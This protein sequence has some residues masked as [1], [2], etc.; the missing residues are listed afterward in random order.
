MGKDYSH[1]ETAARELREA[2]QK[3]RILQ[4][5]TRFVS[6]LLYV[7]HVLDAIVGLLVEEFKL[8]ACS[9]RLLDKD[10]NLRIRSHAGLSRAFIQQSTRKPTVDSYSGECFLTGKI[11]II[12]DSGEIDK[13]ISTT[14]TVCENIRSFAVAPIIVEGEAIG[15]LVTSS[16][17]KGY[18]HERYN[19]VITIIANQI[20]IA[21]R[22]SQ[23]YEEINELN[24]DLEKKVK[25]RTEEL[26]RKTRKLIEVERLAA[27]GKM[28]QR[29]AHDC[30][31]SLTVVGGLARRLDDK[32]SEEDP[33]KEYTRIIVDE[34]KNLEKKVSSIINIDKA[35]L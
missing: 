9:I 27:I 35:D 4:E 33:G 15:V 18:F 29:I 2:E 26:E 3:I 22:I 23:L 20:G 13:P 1:L 6:S 21:I 14:R 17:K 30:R 10:G 19:D 12:N 5:I 34:V 31:N 25:E 16:R 8:D 28:S 11:L 24:R 32:T 7:K